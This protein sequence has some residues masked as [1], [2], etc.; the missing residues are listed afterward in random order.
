M[1]SVVAVLAASICLG[2]CASV[3]RGWSEKITFTSEPQEAQMKTSLGHVCTT[4]CTLKFDRKDEFIATFEREG[5][6]K[7]EIQVTTRLAGAGVA[8]FAGN[9]IVGGVVGMVV[10]TASGAT[11][12]HT[13]NPVV[14]TL[15]RDSGRGPT[16]EK[17]KK[18]QPKAVEASTEAK[19]TLTQ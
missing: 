13:P 2:G 17:A 16:R 3:T 5:Y 4:P 14:A 15:E 19:P 9:V 18:L 8:G 6:K 11:L 12:E 10:D 7:K 1:K